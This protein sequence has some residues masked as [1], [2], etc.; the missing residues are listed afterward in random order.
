MHTFF[1]I[2][3]D[4]STEVFESSADAKPEFPMDIFNLLSVDQ[5]LETVCCAH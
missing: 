5:L 3:D 1:T 2:D 4:V